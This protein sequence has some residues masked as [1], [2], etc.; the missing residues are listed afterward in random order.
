MDTILYFQ[1]P[2]KTSAPD[3]IA[4]R[5]MLDE[6]QAV[7]LDKAKE[8]LK[9]SSLDVSTIANFCGFKAANALWKFFRQETGVSPSEWRKLNS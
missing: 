3:K 8:L 5:S 2:S 9:N 1:S 4:G 7:R 6:I